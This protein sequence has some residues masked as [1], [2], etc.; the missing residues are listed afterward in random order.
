[1][2]NFYVR[3]IIISN[4]HIPLLLKKNKFLE[5]TSINCSVQI[6]KSEAM[7]ILF[8][9]NFSRK[10]KLTF[11]CIA[12][13]FIWNAIGNSDLCVW[14]IDLN[15]L[16]R[17]FNVYIPSREN[18]WYIIYVYFSKFFSLMIQWSFYFGFLSKW[19]IKIIVKLVLLRYKIKS[20]NTPAYN[21]N[22]SWATV[23]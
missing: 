11:S 19:I 10:K 22:F 12:F 21:V 18:Q 5:E 23:S 17:I 1:M 14:W 8:S 7:Q 4:I 20:L 3:F 13:L 15:Y 9:S 16:F 2:F 6:W